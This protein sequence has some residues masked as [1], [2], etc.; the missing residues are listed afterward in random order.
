MTYAPTFADYQPEIEAMLAE[1]WQIKER[2]VRDWGRTLALHVVKNGEE[3]VFM[4]VE[5]F[6]DTDDQGNIVK[7]HGAVDIRMS[8]W[9]QNVRAARQRGGL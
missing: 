9:S 6:Y 7:Y 1:G 8:P 2:I 4:L 3:K 5:Q